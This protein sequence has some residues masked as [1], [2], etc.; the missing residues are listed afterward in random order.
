[1]E[2]IVWSD[3]PKADR[4]GMIGIFVGMAVAAPIAILFAFDAPTIVRYF[5]MA[6]GLLIGLVAG[7]AIGA[8]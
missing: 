3:R 2:I 8:R 5:I 6:A 4:Y 1:M 7:R